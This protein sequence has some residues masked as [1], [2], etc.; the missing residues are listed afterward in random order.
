MV[1]TEH[2]GLIDLFCDAPGVALKELALQ[3]AAV[4]LDWAGRVESANMS[5][6]VPQVLFA[7]AVIVYSDP[8]RVAGAPE[9]A[10]VVEVQRGKDRRKF[11]SWPQYLVGARKAHN[12]RTMLLVVCPDR[13]TA[14]WCRK[15]Y[16]TGI[17]DWHAL[18]P[19]VLGPDDVPVQEDPVEAARKPFET[20]LSGLLHG[21]DTDLGKQVFAAL[22]AAIRALPDEQADRYARIVYNASTDAAKSTFMEA[23]MAV[24]QR[25]PA[26]IFE[27][28]AEQFRDRG[29]AEGKAEGKAEGRVEGQAV[30]LLTVLAARGIEVTD[31]DRERI[32]AC[33]DQELLDI[34]IQTAA[35]TDATT[36]AGL[37]DG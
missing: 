32:M 8:Q 22:A 31:A 25:F 26:T 30:S 34:W 33:T 1:T 29:L 19:W 17:Q 37:L 13:A 14:E 15:P 3:G 24:D 21:S 20:L 6:T 27:A 16:D 23:L 10:L 9:V 11:M 28:Y 5:Q 4:Q 36:A 2:E 7:D 18:K 35:V 12:C